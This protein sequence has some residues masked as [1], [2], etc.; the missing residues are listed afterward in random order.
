MKDSAMYQLSDRVREDIAEKV[1]AYI[2]NCCIAIVGMKKREKKM[3]KRERERE[4]EL[5]EE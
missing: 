4:R 2:R 5:E 3:T 1:R